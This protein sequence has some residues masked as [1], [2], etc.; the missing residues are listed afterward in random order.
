MW[1][2]H[3]NAL[4]NS[5]EIVSIRVVR[6]TLKAKFK[7]GTEETIGSFKDAEDA[8][9]I[10]SSVTKALLFEDSNHPGVI[11]KDTKK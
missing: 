5:T 4:Y 10:F 2:K 7:D 3:N 11:I 9:N 1:I 6:T 8:K